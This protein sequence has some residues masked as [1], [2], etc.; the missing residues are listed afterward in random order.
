MSANEN[1]E[2]LEAKYHR[3]LDEKYAEG[4]VDFFEGVYAGTILDGSYALRLIV[5]DIEGLDKVT[6]KAIGEDFAAVAGEIHEMIT[7]MKSQ[8][9][10]AK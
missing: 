6:L 5:N 1:L 8:K 7:R 2:Y 9:G 4:N 3:I 10:G